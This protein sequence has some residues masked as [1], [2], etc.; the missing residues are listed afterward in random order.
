MVLSLFTHWLWVALLC[1][2]AVALDPSRHISQYAHKA[3]RIED[4]DFVN[5]PTVLA[6]TS[7]GY[8]WIG[9]LNGLF[10][11]DG[12]RFVPWATLRN[13]PLPSDDVTSL[14][15][16]R[17]GSLWIGTF[18]GLIRW[19]NGVLTNYSPTPFY[20]EQIAEGP[21]GEIWV[22][23]AKIRDGKGVLC[24][25]RGEQ[26]K[27][28]GA[29]DGIPFPYARTVAQ[30]RLGNVWVG[31]PTGLCRWRNGSAQL[32]SNGNLQ[33]LQDVIGVS[34]MTPASDSS[35]WVGT[36]R[37]GKG[38]GLQQFK[39]GSWKS[40]SAPGL[41]GTALS[42]TA[43]LVDRDGALWIGTENHGVYRVHAGETDHFTA[44]EGLSS[45]DINAFYQDR[46]G[47]LWVTTSN[48]LDRFHDTA[49]TSFSIREGLTSDE[50]TAVLG[51]SDDTVWI[52]N[53]GALNFIRNNQV[54]R[55]QQKNFPQQLITSL[56]EDHADRL[57]V[58]VDAGLDIRTSDGRFLPVS[59]PDG[60]SLGMILAMT[61][62]IDHNIWA[63]TA[64]GTLLRVR[65]SQVA[66]QFSSSQ[67]PRARDL[68]A[69]PRG[70]I[71]LALENGNLARFHNG[72]LQVVSTGHG[73]N[74]A[75]A[76]TIR[77]ESDGA[78]WASTGNGLVYWKD[79]RTQTLNSRNG[80]ACDAVF[81]TI[82]DN[83]GTY[84]L[85]TGCGYIAISSAEMEQW[86]T[87]PERRVTFRQF[88]TFDGARPF[89]STFR[90]SASK[91]TDGRLWF[92]TDTVLQMIDPA[93]LAVNTLPPPV[94]VEQLVADRKAFSPIAGLE[95]PSGTRDIE[96]DYAALSFVA[97]EKVGFRYRLEGHDAKWQDTGTRRQAFYSDLSPGT[98]QF[99]V[100]ASNNQG[101]WNET[102][103][104]LAFEILP[105]FYQT[106]WF[107][108]LCFALFAFILWLLY[109]L[110]LR[111]VAARMQARL[112]ER[113]QERERIARD[114]HDTLLQGFVSA[115]MQLDVANDRLPAES[116]AKPLV[117]RV[118]QLMQQVSEE[119]RS[120]IR[121]L[122]SPLSQGNDLEEMLSR[123]PEEFRTQEPIDF[124]IFFEGEAEPMHA[125]IRE[126][127]SRI[128]REAVINA[129]RHARASKIYVE[130]KYGIR[131]LAII[132]RDN[133]CGIDQEVLE[134]GR[135]GH[136]GL[137]SMRERAEKLGSKVVVMSRAGAGT[138]VQVSIPAKVAFVSTATNGWWRLLTRWLGGKSQTSIPPVRE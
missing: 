52:A 22:A 54:S 60:S 68:S 89:A 39:D 136:Y 34:V 86:L 45:D 29:S 103:A 131:N 100:T 72:K 18:R 106:T 135:E 57:W 23:R 32:Y 61:E 126:E 84:W 51:A 134:K 7:D 49:V 120:A 50:V 93:R 128:A 4:G 13:K 107:R 48:G 73:S 9:T 113:L 55:V 77:I 44:A 75:P 28:Y 3:W 36:I 115:Y 97:P 104:T 82:L 63:E 91:S 59:K 108:V 80:L 124:R 99:R 58:G 109:R 26:L 95:L 116:P 24:E 122:R 12:V 66:E 132:V 21:S 78:V 16:A 125:V 8:L 69:D 117:Q 53:T 17:D 30:D 110:R 64:L 111:Q 38:L 43:L 42:V 114:L 27:C 123:I 25:V 56:F 33:R 14:L 119:G 105:A 127:V 92:A 71:W 35:L 62:D 133:G 130:I 76:Y 20:V 81:A 10:R 98:Y 15:G 19:K 31:G 96:I 87:Q 138:E 11:F 6:Q 46:E 70:G 118:L 102:G 65:D 47:N 5:A 83:Q 90:P 112:E 94:H 137:S 37:S 67:V 129:F 79:G 88:D 74:P 2:S 101:V 1:C 85:E 41:N 40:Y 121:R